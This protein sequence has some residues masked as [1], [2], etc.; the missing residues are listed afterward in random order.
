MVSLER[1]DGVKEV[2]LHEIELVFHMEGCLVRRDIHR[3]RVET[4]W[5]YIHETMLDVPPWVISKVVFVP[6]AA[7]LDKSSRQSTCERSE[8][9]DGLARLPGVPVRRR[10]QQRG[11]RVR[12]RKRPRGIPVRHRT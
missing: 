4:G 6:D 12:R 5:L 10:K 3:F 2:R 11:I 7:V 8:P 9:A 1:S